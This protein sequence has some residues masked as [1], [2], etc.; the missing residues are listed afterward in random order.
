M[1]LKRYVGPHAEVSVRVA[2][3]DYGIVKKGA[4]VSVPDELASQV[5]WPSKLWQ[6]GASPAPVVSKPAVK[7]A[8]K[9]DK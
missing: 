3:V 7:A 6:D 4:A 9:D 5:E 8:E 1:A 2:G